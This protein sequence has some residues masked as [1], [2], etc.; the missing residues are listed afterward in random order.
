MTSTYAEDAD[1]RVA[2]GRFAPPFVMEG[3][4]NQVYGYDIAMME[5]LCT[6]MKRKCKFQVLPFKQVLQ[7]I[8]DKEAD[9]GVGEI[10]IT[11]QR[12]S[13]VNFSMPYLPS[14]ANFL[15]RSA[16]AKTP[17]SLTLLENKSF[18]VEEGS[19]FPDELIRMGLRNPKIT[20]YKDESALVKALSEGDIDLVLIDSADANYWKNQSANQLSTLGEKFAYG[21][22]LGIAV[23]PSDAD[24][25]KSINQAL[26]LY[27]SS[28]DFKKNYDMYVKPLNYVKPVN[29]V[30][31]NKTTH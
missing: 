15:S 12:A 5:S 30:P 25:L 7:A 8:L 23:N 22:G 14:Y 27:L 6:L 20:P 16:L 31:Q 28:P 11:A 19:V 18:G 2:V 21:F 10:V 1:L 4:N 9:V 17:F 13:I 24:L 3:G 29:F 26:S